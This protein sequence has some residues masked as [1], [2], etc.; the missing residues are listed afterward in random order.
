MCKR[1][2]IDNSQVVTTNNVIPKMQS[3]PAGDFIMGSNSHKLL[4][5]NESPEHKVYLEKFYLDTYEVSNQEYEKCVKEKKCTESE[6]SDNKH[7][8]GPTMPVVGI[9]WFDANKYCEFV[10]K[11]LP[12]EA[13][14]EKAARGENRNIYTWGNELNLYREECYTNIYGKK[15]KCKY[16][17]AVGSFPNDKSYY[18]LYDLNGNVREWVNDFYD[19]NYFKKDNKANPKGPTDSKHKVIKGASFKDTTN[20]LALSIRYKLKPEKKKNNVGFRCA[21]DVRN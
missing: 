9:S 1:K 16:S 6:Y 13:E 14:W 2:N 15:D 17:A 20:N 19:K 18:N 8:N 3:I 12:T 4:R 21:K 5:K 10:G 11:R 7:Y